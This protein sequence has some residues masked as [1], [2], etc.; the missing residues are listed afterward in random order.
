MTEI[1]PT[2]ER[3]LE[4]YIR[5]ARKFGPHRVLATA[6]DNGFDTF[7]LARLQRELRQLA[8]PDQLDAKGRRVSAPDDWG[9][10]TQAINRTIGTDL[11]ERGAEVQFITNTLG[12]SRQ[13]IRRRREQLSM[14]PPIREWH[15]DSGIEELSQ[16]R[17]RPNSW[18]Y[19][20]V[21]KL[22]ERKAR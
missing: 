2:D 19:S 16:G 6:A 15:A 7:M 4:L 1:L 5:H 22:Q 12:V 11:L 18:L 21:A 20:A 10:R 17:K 9:P 14:L 8:V 13:W 3:A